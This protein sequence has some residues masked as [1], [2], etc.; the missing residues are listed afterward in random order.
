MMHLLSSIWGKAFT[1]VLPAFFLA[2]FVEGADTFVVSARLCPQSCIASMTHVMT[3]VVP[4][5]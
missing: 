4:D 3:S 1:A 2:H 5:L